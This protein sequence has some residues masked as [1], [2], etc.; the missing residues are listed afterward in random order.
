MRSLVVLSFVISASVAHASFEM[1]LIEDAY[2]DKIH[3]FDPVNRVS[4]GSFG[5]GIL[6]NAGPICV[7]SAVNTAYVADFGGVRAFNYFTGEL[8][9]SIPISGMGLLK[10]MS[11]TPD[12]NLMVNDG[13]IVRKVSAISGST[14]TTVTPYPNNN[15]AAA[16]QRSN[17]TFMLLTGNMSL[18]GAYVTFHN[19][20]GASTGFSQIDSSL[21]IDNAG[22]FGGLDY[23]GSDLV[24]TLQH[25]SIC[26]TYIGTLAASSATVT[27]VPLGQQTNRVLVSNPVFT[28]TNTAFYL[29]RTVNGTSSYA[30]TVAI[31]PGFPNETYELLPEPLNTTLTSG[32]YGSIAIVLAPEP[33]PFIAVGLGLVT[34]LRRRRR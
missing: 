6:S 3:R 17:G 13:T 22:V 24:I 16:Y 4:L 19:S 15:V 8:L 30:S 21:P 1:M 12:G 28:H 7:N 25:Q 2:G 33:A 14:L 29:Q 9:S 11:L 27:E 10:S 5:N 18:Q 23:R 20:L 31:T 32:G 34:V 26:H